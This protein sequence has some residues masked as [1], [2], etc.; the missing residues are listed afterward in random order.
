MPSS[1]MSTQRSSVGASK[2]VSRTRSRAVRRWTVYILRCADKTLYT[3]IATDVMDRICRHNDGKGAKYTRSRRPVIL[4]WSEKKSSES[5][6]RKREAAIK[7]MT[8][9]EKLALI[10]PE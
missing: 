10:S 2:P 7:K 3:G 9:A 8:R 5:A 6:A 4:A 1:L